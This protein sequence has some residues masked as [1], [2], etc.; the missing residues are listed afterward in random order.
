MI[1]MFLFYIPLIAICALAVLDGERRSKPPADPYNIRMSLQINVSLDKALSDVDPNIIRAA[2]AAL[3]VDETATAKY[4]HY[5]KVT[6][7]DVRF[8]EV[9]ERR[10]GAWEVKY[11]AK[12]ANQKQFDT[13]FYA[14]VTVEQQSNGRFV[15]YT[16]R[17]APADLGQTY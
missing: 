12:P 9:T 16:V 11:W 5:N 17:S 15:G 1:R 3:Y 6:K 8:I 14:T 2:R 7:E 13:R 10:K 4:D